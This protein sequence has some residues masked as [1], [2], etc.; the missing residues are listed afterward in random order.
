MVE[1]AVDMAE[2]TSPSDDGELSQHELSHFI[3]L[4]TQTSL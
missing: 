4:V 3:V 1:N 2:L